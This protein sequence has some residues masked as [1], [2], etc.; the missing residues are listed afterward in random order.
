MQCTVAVPQRAWCLDVRPAICAQAYEAQCALPRQLASTCGSRT[1][2]ERARVSAYNTREQPGHREHSAKNRWT[3]LAHALQQAK[4][5]TSLERRPGEALRALPRQLAS[6][7]HLT[8]SSTSVGGGRNPPQSHW[9]TEMEEKFR[10]SQM[11][12]VTDPICDI[13]EPRKS[14]SRGNFRG[15]PANVAVTQGNFRGSRISVGRG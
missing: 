14:V 2:R 6:A 9:E 1:Q 12:A 3:S 5:L 10:E 11:M 13:H 7:H 8:S 15:S 4:T